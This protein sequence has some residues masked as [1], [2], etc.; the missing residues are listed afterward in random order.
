MRRERWKIVERLLEQVEGTTGRLVMAV[1]PDPLDVVLYETPVLGRSQSPQNPLRGFVQETVLLLEQPTAA[2]IAALLHLPSTVVELVL[3]NLQQVGG[4]VSDTAG[5]WSVPDEAPRF[6]TGG[7]DPP[8]WRRT[9]RLLCY[10]PEPQVL[11]P[12]LPRMR[13]RDLVELGVHKLQGEFAEG[14]NRIASWTAAEGLLRG[15]SEAVRILPLGVT[16][17]LPPGKSSAMPDA[18]VSVE[19]VLVSQCRLDVIA[20]TWASYH[21]GI[22][23]VT[24]RLWSRP[25]PASDAA[26]EP[27]APGEPMLGLSLPERLLGGS[28]L[29]DLG[30]LFDPRPDVWRNLLDD[31]DG[32]AWLRRDLEGDFPAVIVAEQ[33]DAEKRRWQGVSSRIAQE[34]RLL[35]Y[36]TPPP[37]GK[38]ER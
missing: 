32:V 37:A 21:S 5:R 7:S 25:T 19:E 28:P 20:L 35:C 13:L 38:V 9:R 22:W 6:G 8:I 1:A 4:A 15:R 10:W 17:V 11:L 27:F 29:D 12:V 16:S 30:N 24:S 33:A 2:E 3:G 18:P 23:E 34:A 14:Y 31:Q 36:L 26:G